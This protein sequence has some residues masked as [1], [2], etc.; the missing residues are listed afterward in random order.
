MKNYKFLV[1]TLFIALLLGCSKNEDGA[2]DLQTKIK[3][4][5]TTMTLHDGSIIGI[6]DGSSRVLTVSALDDDPTAPAQVAYQFYNL[7]VKSDLDWDNIMTFTDNWAGVETNFSYTH[8]IPGGNGTIKLDGSKTAQAGD[9]FATITLNLPGYNGVKSIKFAGD[10]YLQKVAGAYP[11]G[12]WYSVYSGLIWDGLNYEAVPDDEYQ[13]EELT[14]IV[15]L[16]NELEGKTKSNNDFDVSNLLSDNEWDK[17]LKIAPGV[18][19]AELLAFVEVESA[20]RPAFWKYNQGKLAPAT[21]FEGH[22][23]WKELQKVGKDP[24]M[25]AYDPINHKQS[26]ETILYPRWTK[27]FY[28]TGTAEMERL[29]FAKTIDHDAALKSASWGMFYII[30][31]QYE[32]CGEANVVAFS[33]KMGESAFQQICLAVCYLKS[34]GLTQYLISHDWAAFARKYNGPTYKN[35]KLDTKLKEAYEQ[36]SK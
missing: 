9:I 23:F 16:K 1:G 28:S 10:A 29:R 7:L 19:K 34:S 2:E 30:G 14:W 17:I 6:E 35:Y 33:E 13:E 12:T 18:K 31:N 4:L 8:E 11:V 3:Q 32:K 26:T 24:L 36:Y 15:C 5:Q 25:Y 22:I 20:G 21:Q 27:A